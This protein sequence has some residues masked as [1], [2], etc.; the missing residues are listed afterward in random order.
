[1]DKGRAP[2]RKQLQLKLAESI[3]CLLFLCSPQCHYQAQREQ[4]EQPVKHLYPVFPNN[5]KVESK[6][7]S[8]TALSIHRVLVRICGLASL[9]TGEVS[10]LSRMPYQIN[11]LLDCAYWPVLVVR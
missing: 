9:T 2:A 11:R 3:E 8:P 1:M 7:D 4:H 10:K 6:P 5:N